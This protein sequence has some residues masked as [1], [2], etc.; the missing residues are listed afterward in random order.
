MDAELQ[1]TSGLTLRDYEVLLYLFH[2]PDQGLRMSELADRVLLTPSGITRLVQGLE[3]SC[4]IVREAC[5]KDLRVSYARLSDDGR[6]RF[7]QMREGHLNYVHELFT[8][9]FTS[10]ELSTLELLLAKLPM[11]RDDCSRSSAS[12]VSCE[13]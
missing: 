6:D 7:A 8:G 1:R 12:D 9:R 5:T 13:K 3:E 4:Y 11:T 10:E 2:A